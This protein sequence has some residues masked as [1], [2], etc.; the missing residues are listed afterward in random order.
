MLPRQRRIAACRGTG[1]AA[2]LLEA[3]LRFVEED[4]GR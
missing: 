3:F 1:V 2:A 4:L